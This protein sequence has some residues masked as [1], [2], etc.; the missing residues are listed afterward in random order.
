MGW[1]TADESGKYRG[2]NGKIVL[3]TPLRSYLLKAART[4]LQEIGK[5]LTLRD[6][7]WQSFWHRNER[8]VLKPYW[9]L[10]HRQSF[11]DGVCLAQLLVAVRQTLNDKRESC[12]RCLTPK[13]VLRIATAIADD[14]SDI[15]K[16]L[17][18]PYKPGKPSETEDPPRMVKRLRTRRWPWQYSTPSWPAAYNLA[19]V[20]AAIYAHRNHQLKACMRNPEDKQAKPDA[21]QIKE[22]LRCLAGKVVTSL[23]FAINNPECEMDR[24]SEWIAS[25]PDFGCLHSPDDQC[26]KIQE[27]PGR[28]EAARLSTHPRLSMERRA[29]QPRHRTTWSHI[30]NRRHRTSWMMSGG[31][32]SGPRPRRPRTNPRKRTVAA[33]ETRIRRGRAVKVR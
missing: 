30:T 27:L 6:V 8:G 7:I 12:T 3:C 19:C 11:H 32:G 10:R 17:A 21:G 28:S 9:R 20:Y 29:A 15:A 1:G 2:E 18:I 5:Y 22:E 26:S 33:L 23:E 31:S 14:S 25:D 16:L 24:P 13:K 4:E